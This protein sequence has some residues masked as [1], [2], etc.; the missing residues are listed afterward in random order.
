MKKFSVFVFIF[1]L[2][3]CTYTS[4]AQEVDQEAMMK[5]WEKYMTPGEEHKML[6]ENL[7]K[8]EGDITMWMDPTQPP[9]KTK[10][11]ADYESIFDGRYIV[12]KY[13]G[14]MMGMPFNGMDISGFD[15]AKKVYFTSWIDN[16]GTGVLYVEGTYDKGTNTINFT[17]ETVD[18][19]GNK[20]KVREVITFLDKDHFKFEMYMDMGQG[21]MQSMEIS[22]TR[23]K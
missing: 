5:A 1:S 4:F 20:T 6:A 14:N 12:G 13:S 9:Q 11:T 19:M 22:Y 16:M 17:G 2:L 3:L 21:E 10:G 8:W 15:N 7:G 18:P 23:I